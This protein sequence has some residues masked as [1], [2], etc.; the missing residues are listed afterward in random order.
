LLFYRDPLKIADQ[1]VVLESNIHKVEDS[2]HKHTESKLDINEIRKL[3]QK[4]EKIIPRLYKPTEQTL[5]RKL[6][7]N[8][9]DK[10]IIEVYFV[11]FFL[12]FDHVLLAKLNMFT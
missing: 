10:L 4:V 3:F 1:I 8:V 11:F 7:I 5:I 9:E 12:D 2:Y 6:T